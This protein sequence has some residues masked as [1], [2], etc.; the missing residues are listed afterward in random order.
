MSKAFALIQEGLQIFAD[1]DPNLERNIKIARAVNNAH[2][3]YTELYKEKVSPPVPRPA[4]QRQIK[5]RKTLTYA[6]K[7]EVVKKINGGKSKRAVALTYGINVS[8]I[9][10]IEEARRVAG[11]GFDE[12]TYRL[13]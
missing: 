9:R 5:K 12:T 4:A 6:E 10:E 13:S 3:S 11:R 8:T 1:N 2:S 7:L